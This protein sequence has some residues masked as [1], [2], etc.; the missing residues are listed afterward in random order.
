MQCERR[1][2]I[3]YEVRHMVSKIVDSMD[4]GMDEESRLFSLFKAAALLVTEREEETD[5]NYLQ[6]PLDVG[7]KHLHDRLPSDR[8]KERKILSSRMKHLKTSGLPWDTRLHLHGQSVFEVCLSLILSIFLTNNKRGVMKML[9][10]IDPLQCDGK[11]PEAYQVSTRHYD[12]F[13]EQVNGDCEAT[14]ITKNES[15]ALQNTGY[16]NVVTHYIHNKATKLTSYKNRITEEDIFPY[17]FMF[18]EVDELVDDGGLT[19]YTVQEFPPPEVPDTDVC[20][21]ESEMEE[22]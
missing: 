13:M 3:T 5:F 1:E 4:A 21:E 22:V 11:T 20:C 19:T 10:T 14:C 18:P 2:T 12:A 6:Y 9:K 17:T 15:T 16:C 8:N 7:W